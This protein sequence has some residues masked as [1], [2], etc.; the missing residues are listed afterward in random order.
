MEDLYKPLK[1][2]N[3]NSYRL[4]KNKKCYDFKILTP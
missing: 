2:I 1:V 4:I 3:V